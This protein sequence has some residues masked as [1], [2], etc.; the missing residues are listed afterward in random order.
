VSARTVV[1]R[2]VSCGSEFE[3]RVTQEWRIRCVPCWRI[4]RGIVPAPANDPIRDELREHLPALV[5]L[6]HPDRHGGSALA[7][8]ETA[9]LLGLREKIGGAR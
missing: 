4:H 6:A 5:R 7:N 2:C 8:R 3:R 9:W 1:A